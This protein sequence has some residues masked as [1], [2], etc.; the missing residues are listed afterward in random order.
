MSTL[1]RPRS[2][3]ATASSATL[4]DIS[5]RP[6]I[7]D[8]REDGGESFVFPQCWF[9]TENIQAEWNELQKYASSPSAPTT[10]RTKRKIHFIEPSDEDIAPR[11]SNTVPPSFRSSSTTVI[12]QEPTS[13]GNLDAGELQQEDLISF[14]EP[15]EDLQKVS[16]EPEEI[17][18]QSHEGDQD[19]YGMEMEMVAFHD[20]STPTEELPQVSHDDTDDGEEAKDPVFNFR[21]SKSHSISGASAVPQERPA[22]SRFYRTSSASGLYSKPAYSPIVKAHVAASP[23]RCNTYTTYFG[24][25]SDEQERAT[26]ESTPYLSRSHTASSKSSNSA[27]SPTWDD[28]MTGSA[29]EKSGP[30][31][32]TSS[33]GGSTRRLSGFKG[34]FPLEAVRR[35]LSA[36]SRMRKDSSKSSKRQSP[37]PLSSPDETPA[38]PPNSLATSSSPLKGRGGHSIRRSLSSTSSPIPTPTMLTSRSEPQSPTLSAHVSPHLKPALKQ[39][40]PCKPS[41]ATRV[42]DRSGP[43]HRDSLELA[44]HRLG[45]EWPVV[46]AQLAST[47]DSIVLAKTRMDRYPKSHAVLDEQ[48]GQIMVGGLSPI[49]DAS[50][51]DPRAYW[52]ARRELLA[53]QKEVDWQREIGGHPENDHD[54]PIC[55]VERPRSKRLASLRAS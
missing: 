15:E 33:P 50:P 1:R 35:K 8:Y 30:P 17:A 6:S 32:D 4:D 42:Y 23:I 55:E 11:R 21:E 24:D 9:R 14:E 13:S 38:A 47:R 54:C 45:E 25:D 16:E 5:S 12:I 37:E 19:F 48:T 27:A 49:M 26:S 52:T 43:S 34:E 46:D 22:S 28:R 31:S 18:L 53:K 7:Q 44:R 10:P 41:G 29:S 39:A 20:D 40:G 2:G 36:M 3:S 51:P